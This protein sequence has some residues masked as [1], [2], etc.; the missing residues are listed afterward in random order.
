MYGGPPQPAAR[1]KAPHPPFP[2]LSLN[3]SLPPSLPRSL[4]EN[5]RPL[6]T[7]TA[8]LPLQLSSPDLSKPPPPFASLSMYR[9]L[10]PERH[11]RQGRPRARTPT[12]TL[13]SSPS[14]RPFP[15]SFGAPASGPTAGS[16][17]GPLLPL[18]TCPRATRWDNCLRVCVHAAAWENGCA[19]PPAA[20][21]CD[22]LGRS[23]RR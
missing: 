21:L 13:Y 10:A 8:V 20:C 5:A 7:H 16:G 17:A 2:F 9:P 14:T 22:P 4:S 1:A 23:K 18:T 15:D 19:L 11:E 3:P 6:S 12:H